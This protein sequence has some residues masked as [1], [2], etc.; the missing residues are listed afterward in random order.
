MSTRLRFAYI[1]LVLCLVSSLALASCQSATTT[2]DE[3]ETV[4]GKVV[5]QATTEE[6]EK[7]QE[8]EPEVTETGPEM[9]RDTRGIL[10]EKPQYGGTI[11]WSTPSDPTSW[12]PYRRAGASLCYEKLGFA[13]WAIDPSIPDAGYT[14]YYFP[15][16]AGTGYL[17][18]S[19]ETPDI[20]TIIIHLRKGVYWQDKPPVNGRELT[21]E[22]VVYVYHRQYGLGGGFDTFSPYI[23]NEAFVKVKSI[24]ATDKYTILVKHEPSVE[25]IWKFF[26]Y[27]YG[28]DVYPREAVEQGDLE[29]WKQAVGTGAFMIDDY[30]SGASITYVKNPN[31]WGYDERHPENKL[32]YADVFKYMII[33]DFATELAAFRSG[34]ID[35]MGTVGGV[36]SPRQLDGILRTNPDTQ[37]GQW[38]TYGW[39]LKMKY[40]VEPF[41][42][43]RVR[44]A[45]QMAINPEV[46]S[47]THYLGQMSPE[48]KPLVNMV[49]YYTPFDQLPEEVIAAHTYN[50]EKAKEL[51]A[52]AGY[53]NGFKTHILCTNA[54]DIDLLQIAKGYLTEIG[55]DL[56]IRVMDG[57][58]WW[59]VCSTGEAEQMVYGYG[60][61]KSTGTGVLGHYH[62]DKP[63]NYARINDP[64]FNDLFDQAL[65]ATTVDDYVR[66]C[67]EAN[68]YSFE[69]NWG[70]HLL[71]I[72]A[73]VI[74]QPWYKGYSGEL[75]LGYAQGGLQSRTWIDQELKQTMGK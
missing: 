18:E 21:A 4:K 15:P 19:W 26:G 53:P 50:P 41:D 66:I 46:I 28:D 32:P 68:D 65:A 27:G 6:E 51:L 70:V 1:T 61:Q 44:R 39:E 9:V 25:V 62:P 69:Q 49:G 47:E 59:G 7:E 67:K 8:K 11:S 73:F 5:E 75:M 23:G 22:D 34:K 74:W 36:I 29:D 54:Q 20:E 45:L 2:T 48:Y 17:A 12:D 55:V 40:N 52:E 43:I 35:K 58:A 60:A 42:D 63:W 30:V 13:N 31:Y 56:D 72:P 10:V 38:N 14:S 3:G 64:H 71:P 37:Y 16:E 33:G 24:E 57:G